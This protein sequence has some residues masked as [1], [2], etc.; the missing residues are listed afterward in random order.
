MKNVRIFPLIFGVFILFIGVIILLNIVG[1]HV[2]GGGIFAVFILF[3]G[4]YLL[5]RQK[6]VI[7]YIFIAFGS[8]ILLSIFDVIGFIISIALIYYGYRIIRSKQKEEPNFESD[9]DN[10][11]ITNTD[12]G[13]EEG[14]TEEISY[15]Y[16][17]LTP[18]KKHT[19]IG[20]CLL[21]GSRWELRDLDIWHGIGEVKIDLSRANIPDN[22]STI[23][24]NGWIGDVDIFVPYDLDVSIIA[25]VGVGEIKI[26]GNKESGVNQSTAVETN[27][28]RK[29]IKRVEIV[30]NLFVGD[31][32]VN[33]L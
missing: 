20:S 8:L 17:I 27:G 29:E 24:I 12:Q 21:T 9:I 2:H 19:L 10:E 32:D 23:I 14:S 15:S 6:K 4:Y 28:Y 18:Q 13:A 3:I 11:G 31:I 26:F 22:K 30:I 7:G 33:Y 1:I 16:R 5:K 25:R